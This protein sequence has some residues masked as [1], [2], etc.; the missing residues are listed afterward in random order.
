MSKG[1]TLTWQAIWPDQVPL[2]VDVQTYSLGERSFVSIVA[3]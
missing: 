1:V 2:D 3:M